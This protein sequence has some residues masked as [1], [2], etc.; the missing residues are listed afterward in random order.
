[1]CMSP[2]TIIGLTGLV[3]DIR[4]N[5][6]KDVLNIECEQILDCDVH[7][8]NIMK[9]RIAKLEIY[10]SGAP[11]GLSMKIRI[12]KL[13]IYYAGAA[14]GWSAM[15]PPENVMSPKEVTQ[16]S[17]PNVLP[18]LPDCD[19]ITGNYQLKQCRQDQF[20]NKLVDQGNSK[21]LNTKESDTNYLNG[22]EKLVLGPESYALEFKKRGY[23]PKNMQKVACS[24][25]GNYAT[26]QCDR[27]ICQCVNPTDAKTLGNAR[28]DKSQ[29]NGRD[30]TCRCALQNYLT[31]YEL[32]SYRELACD[33]LGNYDAYQCDEGE[34]CYCVDEDGAPITN[35]GTMNCLGQFLKDYTD[36]NLNTDQICLMLRKTLKDSLLTKGKGGQNMA[37][38]L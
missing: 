10:Y 7:C 28:V 13:E 1:M 17:C 36:A 2:V 23:N 29:L 38:L 34:R 26:K 25:D 5:V 11:M 12:A 37:T 8:D 32:Q 33:Q 6:I 30:M 24:A 20:L 22:C 19:H 35:E 3:D 18:N 9:I 4:F 15:H 27:E 14:M 16:L 31:Q 21:K